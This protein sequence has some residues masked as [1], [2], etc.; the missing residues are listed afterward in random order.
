MLILLPAL[1]QKLRI[2]LSSADWASF[3]ALET[4]KQS[5]PAKSPGRWK[6]PNSLVND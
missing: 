1:Y 3:P 4:G 5:G 2:G 6:E